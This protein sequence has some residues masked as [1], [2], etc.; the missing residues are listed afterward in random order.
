MQKNTV[1]IS[2]NKGKIVDEIK[3]SQI[4]ISNKHFIMDILEDGR[5][6]NIIEK[7]TKDEVI[8]IKSPLIPKGYL[9][10]YEQFISVLDNFINY[11]L[12]YIDS[13]ELIKEII[14]KCL[15]DSDI[16]LSKKYYF[17]AENIEYYK[18]NFNFLI[19]KS[20]YKNLLTL[21]DE[22]KDELKVININPELITLNNK[23]D[24][25][26]LLRIVD[27]L[28][29][30]NRNDYKILSLFT[31]IHNSRY[32]LYLDWYKMLL[33]KYINNIDFIMKYAKYKNNLYN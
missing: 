12:N 20:F 28:V 27:E 21:K 5:L 11:V 6:E 9:T 23:N 4:K 14:I 15:M 7:V 8:V 2:N 10:G 18:Y 32:N 33:L 31:E 25:K 29:F 1:I 24:I 26:N 30:I 16:L 22:M 3:K 19:V 17:D 13:P